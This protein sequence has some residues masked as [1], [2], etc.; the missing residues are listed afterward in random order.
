MKAQRLQLNQALLKI[1]PNVTAADKTE[2]AKELNVS[3]QTIC[4]YLTGRVTNNDRAIKVL[5]FF[6]QRIKNRQQ[7]IKQLCQQ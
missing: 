6:L 1:A 4:Y 3:K 7:E 5:E 2:C